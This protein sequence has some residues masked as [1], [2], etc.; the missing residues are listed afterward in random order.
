MPFKSVPSFHW[1]AQPCR[2]PE[3]NPPR[4]IYLPQ[5]NYIWVCPC[6]GEE[7]NFSSS[8]TSWTTSPNAVQVPPIPTQS[9]EFDADGDITPSTE[10]FIKGYIGCPKGWMDFCEKAWDTHY[11]KITRSNGGIDFVTGGWSGNEMVIQAMKSNIVMWSCCWVSSNRG[12][13]HQFSVADWED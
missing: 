3:H 6:C 12:G 9:P 10:D 2:S 8:S 4:H 13:L 7:F 11:G 1:N 5:G